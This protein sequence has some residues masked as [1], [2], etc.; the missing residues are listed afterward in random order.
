MQLIGVARDDLAA[1]AFAEPQRLRCF[2]VE[3]DAEFGA[4]DLDVE[5]VLAT[6]G[7]LRHQQRPDGAARETDDHRRGV[8]GRDRCGVGAL[9]EDGA[10]CR[11][12]FRDAGAGDE[13]DEVDEMRPDVGER[14]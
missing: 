13:L 6:G 9:G 4:G 3:T 8:L 10:K 11:T 12:E 5:P 7:D 2:L 1:G 14:A